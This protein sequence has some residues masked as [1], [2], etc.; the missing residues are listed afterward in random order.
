MGV[1]G[2]RRF[3]GSRVWGFRGLGV[4]GLGVWGLGFRGLGFKVCSCA[5]LV[6]HVRIAPPHTRVWRWRHITRKATS[7]ACVIELGETGSS[8]KPAR[9][10]DATGI[11]PNHFLLGF[12]A[13]ALNSQPGQGSGAGSREKKGWLDLPLTPAPPSKTRVPGIGRL[14]GPGGP[15]PGHF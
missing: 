3:R 7:L 6:I 13:A 10:D 14:G 1:W 8:L 9:F 2:F 11:H 12:R 15:L 4:Q 5:V